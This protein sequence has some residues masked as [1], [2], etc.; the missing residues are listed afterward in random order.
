MLTRNGLLGIVAFANATTVTNLDAGEKLFDS[1]APAGG[2]GL[3]V[4]FNKRSRTNFCV[5]VAFGKGGAKG[6]YFALQ[7]AF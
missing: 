4:L 2:A 5:D 6:L 7:D 3:R 1:Y